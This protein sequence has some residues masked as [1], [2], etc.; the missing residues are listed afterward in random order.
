VGWIFLNG[1]ILIFSGKTLE[2]I[3]PTKYIMPPP[4]PAK[5]S[6]IQIASIFCEV[7]FTHF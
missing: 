2:Q 6:S 3:L 5:S 4:T 1:F 7:V